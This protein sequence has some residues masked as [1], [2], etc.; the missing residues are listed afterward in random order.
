[1]GFLNRLPA[2][3]DT[4]YFRNRAF[5]NKGRD[6]AVNRR[7]LVSP[8]HLLIN[9]GGPGYGYELLAAVEIDLD[10]AASWDTQTPTDYTVPVNRA[11]KDF[12]IYACQPVSGTVPVILISEASTY[13]SG[14]IANNSR[15]IGGFH[16]MPY[17]TAPT[18]LAAT[19]TTVG[20]VIQPTSINPATRYLYRCTARSGD[21]KTGAVEPTW[22]TTPGETVVDN[23]VTWTC[24]ANGCENLPVGHPYLGYLMGDIHFNSIWDLQDRPRCSPEAMAKGSSTPSDGLPRRWGNI[25]LSSGDG[26]V[27]D[28]VFGATIKDTI[29][30]NTFVH[31]AKLR[32][33]RLMRDTEFQE[34]AYGGNEQTNIAG[35]ADPGICT[36]PLDTAGKSMI[37]YWGLIGMAGV[38][39]QWLDEQ[40]YRYDP[41]GSIQAAAQTATITYVASLEGV[42]VYLLWDGPIPYL[43]ANI[44]ADIWIVAGSYKFQIKAVADPAAAGGVQIYFRDAAANPSRLYAAVQSGQTAII[45][46]SNS[47]FGLPIVYHATPAT[48]GVELRYDNVTHNRLEAINA[49]GV[50]A[51]IDLSTSPGWSWYALPGASGQCY[52]QGA[53]GDVKLL[54]GGSWGYGTYCGSRCRA[55]PDRRSDASSFIGCRAVAEPA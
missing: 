35:T 3:Q 52:K 25:Y 30:W 53:V 6:T 51:T 12:Y 48:Q 19:V 49:G 21:Y 42:A 20:Y 4:Y 27:S 8:S 9:I 34:F 14:Y 37:S 39:Y 17:T 33:K 29:D 54:A 32:G 10:A 28:S 26:T 22:P 7:T 13:P 1:M 44:A 41:D 40:S 15:K 18:W 46:A 36:F 31:Y 38:M 23:N 47:D 11:G 24:N 5:T 2:R 55:A 16:C 43:G 50:N 45:Q